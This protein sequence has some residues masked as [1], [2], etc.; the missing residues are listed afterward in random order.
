MVFINYIINAFCHHEQV[1]PKYTDFSKAFDLVDHAVLDRVLA[2]YGFS[3][4]LLSWFG[5]N[6]SNRQTEVN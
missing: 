1:Y 4:P 6:L 5:S 2:D 3:E